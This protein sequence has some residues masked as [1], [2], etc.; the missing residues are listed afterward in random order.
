MI[1]RRAYIKRSRPARRATVNGAR[2]PVK[3]ST[4][5]RVRNVGRHKTEWARAYH[6][7]ARVAFVKSLPCSA[8]G[9]DGFPLRENAHTFSGG[10]GRKADYETIIPLCKPCHTR[11]HNVGWLA[12]LAMVG[13]GVTDLRRWLIAT[14]ADTETKWQESQAR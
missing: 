11:Q 8:C 2:K 7:A 14:A 12:L 10:T 5:V 3:R 1:R 13:S 9:F 4:R 6:S